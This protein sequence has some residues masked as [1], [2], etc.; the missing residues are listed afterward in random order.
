MF[1]M[2]F[3]L[4]FLVSC[5]TSRPPP[6]QPLVAPPMTNQQL[7]DSAVKQSQ[8]IRDIRKGFVY[9]DSNFFRVDSNGVVRFKD[10]LVFKVGQFE[11]LYVRKQDT[12]NHRMG[13]DTLIVV[14]LPKRK[15]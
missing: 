15:K 12:T 9:L 7:T 5:T 14:P 3:L 10:S 4:V 6:Q 11:R 13:V 8:D 1:R 2:K